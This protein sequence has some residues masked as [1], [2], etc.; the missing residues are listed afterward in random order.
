MKVAI[1]GAGYTGLAAAFDLAKAGAEVSIY[2]VA[3]QAGGLASGFIDEGW[4]WP[5][6]YHYHHVFETDKALKKWLK[7]LGLSSLL[8]FSSTRTFSLTQ[9]DLAQFDS[10]LTLLSFPDLSF[11]SKVRTGLVMAGL[12]LWP[13]GKSLEKYTAHKFLEFSMGK[14]SWNKIWKPLFV[15]KFGNLASEIN[16]AWFWARIFARSK[17]LGYFQGGFQGLTDSVVEKLQ[18][19]HIT[20]CF[21]T[22]VKN[23]K[24][25]KNKWLFFTDD[26]KKFKFDKILF[27]GN[28]KQLLKI[29]D[30][31]IKINYQSKLDQLQS[32]SALTL[33]LVLDKPFFDENIYWL[34][35]NRVSWPF[36]A[37][38]EHSN[39]IDKKYYGNKNIVYVGKYLN[40]KNPLFKKNKDE[41]LAEYD[42]FL[43]ELSP[44][45]KKNLNKTFLYKA[46]FAQP[47]VK[48]DH[49]KNIPGVT[50]PLS[51]LYFVGMEQVYP[52]DRGIN[53]AIQLGR[54]TAKKIIQKNSI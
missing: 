1:I 3:D 30:E 50:T 49:S 26:N 46:R 19:M 34:N 51:D 21:N 2:E 8:F 14:E 35:V 39:L 27:T 7:D 20:F 12:K 42:S 53:Y 33:I 38:V 41:V 31:K 18:S 32:L 22:K 45:Y 28:S 37:V 54:E 4:S 16:M 10:P 36:L 40:S 43:K 44:N 52:F 23:L 29:V 13:W 6:E 25:S 24:K 15:G 5:I 17:K 9:S 11:L 48:I 47:V